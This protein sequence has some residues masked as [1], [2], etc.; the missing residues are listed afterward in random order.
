MK[1]FTERETVTLMPA[2]HVFMRLTADRTEKCTG[3]IIV[4][5]SKMVLSIPAMNILYAAILLS[6]F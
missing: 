6:Q 4:V 5:R 3:G 1:R 2:G